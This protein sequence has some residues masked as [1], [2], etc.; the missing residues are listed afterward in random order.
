MVIV[1]WVP[2]IDPLIE[3]HV[4]YLGLADVFAEKLLCWLPRNLPGRLELPILHKNNTHSEDA[5]L[6]RDY[7]EHH[8]VHQEQELMVATRTA[9][10]DARGRKAGYLESPASRFPLGD[11]LVEEEAVKCLT[12]FEADS[13]SY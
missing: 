12:S 13:P 10:Y 6:L 8:P 11:W 1:D 5:L 2:Q 7:W 3:G 4:L 9:Y